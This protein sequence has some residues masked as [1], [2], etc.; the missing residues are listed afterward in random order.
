M[1]I[2]MY[3]LYVYNLK[4]YMPPRIHNMI[5]G[6]SFVTCLHEEDKKCRRMVP[7]FC[8][9]QSKP[10]SGKISGPSNHSPKDSKPK[11]LPLQTTQE[12][13]TFPWDAS[14]QTLFLL[15]QSLLFERTKF[16]DAPIK[17]NT[18]FS[19]KENE[20]LLFNKNMATAHIPLL[21]E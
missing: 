5:I 21:S 14:Q 10:K 18:E 6:V 8:F 7:P 12:D 16:I 4:F 9:Q 3:K 11:R 19:H 13:G 20:R 2:C 15:G 1:Y 17:N